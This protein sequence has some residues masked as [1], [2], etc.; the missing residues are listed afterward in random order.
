[1]DRWISTRVLIVVVAKMG[2]HET[3]SAPSLQLLG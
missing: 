2:A 1:M 3:D